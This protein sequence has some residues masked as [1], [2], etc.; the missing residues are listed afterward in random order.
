MVANINELYSVKRGLNTFAKSIDLCQP[1]QSA[2]VDMGQKLFAIF[3]SFACFRTVVHDDCVACLTNYFYEAIIKWCLT[4]YEASRRCVKPPLVISRRK[5]EGMLF[6]RCQSIR[7][8]GVRPH[9]SCLVRSITSTLP[10]DFN[11]IWHSYSP[12]WFAISNIFFR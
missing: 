11:T 3:K 12:S 7:P 2:Q 4:L 8:S 5:A 10:T 9:K 6:W 1:A